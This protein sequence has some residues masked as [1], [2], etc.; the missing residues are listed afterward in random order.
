MRPGASIA[1]GTRHV[2]G[3]GLQALLVA[4]IIAT[5]ALA[6][7]AIYKPA[8]FVSGVDTADAGRSRAWLDLGG[9][10]LRTAASADYTVVGGD[11]DP[12]MA[13]HI[14][15]SEPYCCR[16]FPVT[17]DADG[18]IRFSTTASAPGTYLVE[19]YQRLNGRKL[20]LMA[21]LSFEVTD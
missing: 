5:V 20:T 7:S 19:A 16:F 9:S 6:M 14:V 11:F 3:V 8:G 13:V 4:A 2:A 18:G 15:L 17:P 21:K 12:S 1:R 10:D